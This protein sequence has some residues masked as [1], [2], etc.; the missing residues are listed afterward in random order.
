MSPTN[1]SLAVNIDFDRVAE[2]YDRYVTADFDLAFWVDVARRSDAPRLELMCGTGR[3]TLPILH[4]GLSI[5]GLDYS[6]GLLQVFRRKL[7][8][9]GLAAP[10]HHADARSFDLGKKYTLV[11]IGFHALAEVLA[12]DD[13][14]RVLA[15]VHRHLTDD[16]QLWLSIHNPVV[17]RAALDGEERVLGVFPMTDA[18]EELQLSGR[19]RLDERTQIAQ[20]AQTYSV[21]RDGVEVRRIALPIRFHLIA[22]DEL[23]ALLEASG[24]EIVERYGAY[25][26]SP[27]DSATSPFFIVRCRAVANRP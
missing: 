14:A 2:L 22:P 27:F 13:K 19:Y 15:C 17:R 8:E 26:G 20:G 21:K 4:A 3:I 5:E 1:E 23:A 12:N 16:G 18:R 7:D 25:D 10:L 24:L 9:E 6:A 11:F